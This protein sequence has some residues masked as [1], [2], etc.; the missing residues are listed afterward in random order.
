MRKLIVG[1]MIG[2]LLPLAFLTTGGSPTA[3]RLRA[4]VIS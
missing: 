3:D 2:V 1:M 4:S